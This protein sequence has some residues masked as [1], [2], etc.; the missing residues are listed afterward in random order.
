LLS[1]EKENYFLRTKIEE[2][3]PRVKK[4][5]H[6]KCFGT[7]GKAQKSQTRGYEPLREKIADFYNQDGFETR[8]ENI[9]ITSGSQQ[10]LDII[11]R[12]HTKK[13]ITIESPSYLSRYTYK[14]TFVP[15]SMRWNA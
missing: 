10:A 6:L 13:K 7:L 12:Y 15:S 2:Q 4:K 1:G 3:M 14:N 11:C 5:S 9:M 8:A